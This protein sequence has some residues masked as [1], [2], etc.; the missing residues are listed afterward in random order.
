MVFGD[1]SAGRRRK[2]V[3]EL[4]HGDVV[5]LVLL[6]RKKM[7]WNFGSTRIRMAAESEIA[8]MMLWAARAQ[9]DKEEWIRK[10]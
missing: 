2:L 8:G 10:G 4:R 7:G 9:E 5:L 1:W 3:R 6:A